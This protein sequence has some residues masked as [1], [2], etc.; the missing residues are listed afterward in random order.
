MLSIEI[1]ET[2]TLISE[3]S[4][5][6]LAITIRPILEIEYFYCFLADANLGVFHR[7]RGKW[8]V[9]QLKLLRF[10]EVGG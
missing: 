4:S 1:D 3:I 9:H 6:K 10:W 7:E 8:L 2:V 5:I